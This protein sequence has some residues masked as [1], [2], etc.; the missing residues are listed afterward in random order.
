[1]SMRKISIVP[2]MEKGR[3][4]FS[5]EHFSRSLPYLFPGPFLQYLLLQVSQ[6]IRDAL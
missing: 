5:G 4:Q 3:N 1:M 2:E 6:I